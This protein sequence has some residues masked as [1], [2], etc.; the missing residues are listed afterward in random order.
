MFTIDKM[1]AL[2]SSLEQTFFTTVTTGDRLLQKFRKLMI[3]VQ[4]KEIYMKLSVM[5]YVVI[6]KMLSADISNFRIFSSRESFR[7]NCS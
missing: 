5:I 6:P 4:N 7:E 2:K 1:T 3:Q